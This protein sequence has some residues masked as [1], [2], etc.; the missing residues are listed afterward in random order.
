[1]TTDPIKSDI[2]PDTRFEKIVLGVN[3]YPDLPPGM[4]LPI[5]PDWMTITPKEAS[6]D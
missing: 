6:G 3:A 5:S 2:S 1:L 4:T